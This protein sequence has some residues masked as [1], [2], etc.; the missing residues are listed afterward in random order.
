MPDIDDV[1]LEVIKS[2]YAERDLIQRR[3]SLMTAFFN[4]LP[5]RLKNQN[6]QDGAGKIGIMPTKII[7]RPPTPGMF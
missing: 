7:S 4:E 5:Q 3:G 1:M 2:L 6:P